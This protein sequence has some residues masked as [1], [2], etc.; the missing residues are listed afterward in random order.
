VVVGPSSSVL[1]PAA[2][3]GLC[4]LKEGLRQY[5]Y[6]EYGGHNRGYVGHN[7]WYSHKGTKIKKVIENEPPKLNGGILIQNTI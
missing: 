1:V 5:N 7:D 3:R 2:C 4:S 6:R